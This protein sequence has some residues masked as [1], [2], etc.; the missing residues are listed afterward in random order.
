MDIKQLRYLVGIAD[1]QHVGRAAERLHV[2]QPAL[3][4]QLRKLEEEVGSPLFERHHRGM[5]LTLAGQVMLK[6]SRQILEQIEEARNEI[7][8]LS[9]TSECL[10]RIGT[11]Q[12]MNFHLIP[13]AISTLQE[14]SPNIHVRVSELSGSLLEDSIAKED[15]DFGIGF[16]PTLRDDLITEH[17]FSEKFLLI[18]NRS[19]PLAGQDAID[20]KQLHG[21]PMALLTERFISRRLF[22]SAALRASIRPRVKVETNTTASLL[23]IARV[24]QLAVVLP[25]AAVPEW[26]LHEVATLTLKNPSLQRSVGLIWG[27]K[28]VRSDEAIS[29]ASCIRERFTD[30]AFRLPSEKPS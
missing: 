23:L 1:E 4:Q 30:D 18:V 20:F 14:R 28:S 2:T 22:D 29:L 27:K 12:S 3:S 13:M 16:L 26:I 10:I 9:D 19:H 24:S 21:Q 5:R 15:L 8:S 6:H 25:K 7:D 11:I 17:L